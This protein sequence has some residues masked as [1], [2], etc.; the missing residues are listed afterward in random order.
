M[1]ETILKDNP[2]QRAAH[3]IAIASLFQAQDRLERPI[4][5]ENVPGNILS[6]WLRLIFWKTKMPEDCLRILQIPGISPDPFS[7]PYALQ[8]IP[9]IP[10]PSTCSRPQTPLA[11][12]R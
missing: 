12:Y 11:G 9:H 3:D 1:W 6:R 5:S 10:D 4:L 8:A 7:F 2:E